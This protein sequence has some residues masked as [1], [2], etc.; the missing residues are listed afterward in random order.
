M[1]PV[2]TVGLAAT[3]KAQVFESVG[4]SYAEAAQ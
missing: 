4:D 3:K 1:E 2:R